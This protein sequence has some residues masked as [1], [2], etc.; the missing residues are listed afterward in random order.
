ML[1]RLP[2]GTPPPRFH[3]APSS[4]IRSRHCCLKLP[5]NSP[6]SVLPKLHPVNVSK[7][8]IKTLRPP[9]VASPQRLRLFFVKPLHLNASPLSSLPA[10][11]LL[12]STFAFQ[13]SSNPASVLYPTHTIPSETMAISIF[14][15]F[16]T[17]AHTTS[18]LHV[19]FTEPVTLGHVKFSRRGWRRSLN[20]EDEEGDGEEDTCSRER[21]CGQGDEGG[22]S[23]GEQGGGRGQRGAGD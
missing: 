19:L 10:P 1:S 7:Q 2:P 3:P 5:I 6:L 22:G 8:R 13:V 23:M 4:C 11:L 18:Q 16:H 20:D 21:E 14:A 17:A 15:F 9:D 12:S